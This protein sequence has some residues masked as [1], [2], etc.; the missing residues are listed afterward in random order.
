MN[1]RLLPSNQYRDVSLTLNYQDSHFWGCLDKDIQHIHA[2]DS[3]TLGIEG[4]AVTRKKPLKAP[5][6]ND[7]LCSMTT[8]K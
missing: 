7:Q 8:W 6:V 2:N 1:P 3:I 5:V 4:S